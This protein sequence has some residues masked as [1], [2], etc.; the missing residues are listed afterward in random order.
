MT[1]EELR[2]ELITN[3]PTWFLKSVTYKGE[4]T[5]W[6]RG[7]IEKEIKKRGDEYVKWIK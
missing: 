4:V 7:I 3:V 2:G 1:L 6:L 5:G